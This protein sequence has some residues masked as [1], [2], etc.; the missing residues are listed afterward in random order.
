MN[1]MIQ[2]YSDLN[3]AFK[4]HPKTGDVTLLTNEDAVRRSLLH[5]GMMLPY[6]I[7]FKPDAHGHVR[8][9]LFEIP[10]D[11]TRLALASNI[12]WA[13]TTLEPR[14]DIKE[15]NAVLDSSEAG[16]NIEVV[17]SVL[18]LIGEY[19]AQFYLQRIR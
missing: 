13:L 5:I 10:S 3:L 8:E 18:S 2:Y 11:A 1:M 4:P 19:K 15:I 7:P 16:Y 14:A 12:K 9:L 6:D 17:F